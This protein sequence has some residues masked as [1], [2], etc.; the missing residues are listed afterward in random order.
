MHL[1]PLALVAG[2]LPLATINATYL[3]SASFGHVAWCIP[4]LDSCTSISATG[5]YPPAYF[6]FKGAMIPAAVILM[7]YWLLNVH[8]LKQ[9][10]CCHKN[11]QRALTLLGIAAG[12][13]L[14]VYAVLLGSIPPE[15]RVPRHTGVIAFFGFSFFAQ[16]LITWLIDQRPPM[17]SHYSG[18]LRWLKILL[19]LD[20]VLGLA[21]VI[22]G[23]VIPD[24]YS[25]IDNAVAWNFTL[26]LCLHIMLTADLWRR[27]DFRFNFSAK[28]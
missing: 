10:G 21:T 28:P 3:L 17:G 27:T 26:L 9:L 23:F 7:A 18:H 8:W 4:Y 12:S 19:S 15:Y 20:M 14:I 16:L 11:W 1:Y 5:R 13:G 24:L 2:L 6:V 22:A 25:Q